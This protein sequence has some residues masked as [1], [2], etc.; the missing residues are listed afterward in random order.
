M[1]GYLVLIKTFFLSQ[2]VCPGLSWELM[3]SSSQTVE[4]GSEHIEHRGISYPTF[5]AHRACQY[6]QHE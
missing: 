2:E 4:E 3:Q 1:N 6:L 5:P